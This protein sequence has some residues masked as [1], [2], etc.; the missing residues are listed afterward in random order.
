MNAKLEA[1]VKT[2]FVTSILIIRLRT[3]SHKNE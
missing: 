3:V 1:L 2:I